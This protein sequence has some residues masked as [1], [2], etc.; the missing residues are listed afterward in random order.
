MEASHESVHFDESEASIS[1]HEDVQIHKDNKNA[2][3][4]VK[5]T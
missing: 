3:Y 4:F 2:N 1:N 5:N